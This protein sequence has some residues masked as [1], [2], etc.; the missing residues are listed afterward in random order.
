[1]PGSFP[2]QAVRRRP[3]HDPRETERE[4]LEAAEE[5]L[6]Q[7]PFREVTVEQVMLRTGLKRP[8]F[9]AHFSDRYDLMLRV[10]AHIGGELLTKAE[11]WLNGDD[12]RRDIRAALDG[13]ASV[14]LTQGPVLRALADAAPTDGRVESAYRTLVQTFIDATAERIRVEQA[15][16]RTDPRLDPDET[17]R[18]LIWLCERYLSE[19]F[20][21]PPQEDVEKVVS[22]LEQIWLATLYG[23]G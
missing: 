11:R 4:I 21:R 16:G 14:Y 15:D 17:A 20:G 1:M 23:G 18:A 10:V 12:P 19:T 9:Y 6:R 22:V 5:L 7:A 3:R 2:E 13:I 8:A